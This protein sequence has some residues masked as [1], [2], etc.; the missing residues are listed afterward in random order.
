[1]KKLGLYGESAADRNYYRALFHLSEQREIELKVFEHK[2]FR[3]FGIKLWHCSP[4]TRLL[5]E[6]LTGRAPHQK[7]PAWGTLVRTLI[8]PFRL[9][10]Q[11]SIVA[12]F[13]PYSIM[14]FYL[15]FLK[16]IGKDVTYFTSWPYWDGEHYV[17]KPRLGSRK[18]WG[19][20]L[21]G[22][23]AV[24]VTRTSADELARLGAKV[25]HIPHSVDVHLF[26]PAKKRERK[27]ITLLHVGRVV[28][29]KGIG[30]LCAVFESLLEK[31]PHLRL[32][33]VGDGPEVRNIKDR[34]GVVCK[35]HV[36]DQREL[37][38]EYQAADLFVLNSF[39][40]D[41]WEELFGIS[42][43][44]A[45]ACGLPCIATDCVGPKELVE[46][47]VN[48]FIIPQ[49]DRRAL[50]QKLE[51]LILDPDLRA[52]LGARARERTL[53]FALESTARKWLEAISPGL[54]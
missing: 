1:M 20:F 12:A 42:L 2:G 21:K 44:E 34:R 45:M 43:V 13:A 8:H 52:K 14:G 37:V 22:S 54:R 3:W 41:G 16:V 50:H 9:L 31:Y 28:K 25:R 33:V 24:C 47:G 26:V 6:K 36:A 53:D 46:D 4:F 17:H 29:E 49:K 19:L 23:K 35:G 15:L 40:V 48:G 27:D 7:E 39:K 38:R 30:G 5:V 51:Q 11:R 18:I 32:V 10:F